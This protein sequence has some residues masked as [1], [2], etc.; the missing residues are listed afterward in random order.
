MRRPPSREGLPGEIRPPH[1]LHQQGNMVSYP[2]WYCGLAS[3]RQLGLE[4]DWVY[5]G[6]IV[7]AIPPHLSG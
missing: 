4:N 1:P 6:H 7:A 2:H 5:R 3:L